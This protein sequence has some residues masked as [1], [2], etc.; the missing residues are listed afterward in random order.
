MSDTSVIPASIAV[1]NLFEDLLGR[2]VN[3]AS[4]D[5]MTAEDLPT[6]VIALYTDTS[7]QLY[8]VLGLQ[9]PLAAN[10]GAA[11]GLLPVGAAEDSIEEGKLFPN[12]AENVFELC[13]VLTSL[14]NREGAPHIKL[15]Q[16]IYPGMD[17]PNDARAHLLALGKRLDLTVEVARYGK[18][19]LSLSLV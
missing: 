5:P 9:L 1:R 12:L 3:V 18:G 19:K 4:G 16:V 7:Q 14:L 2:D 11:L 13:N 8:A 10:A 15:Y 6:G 17:L